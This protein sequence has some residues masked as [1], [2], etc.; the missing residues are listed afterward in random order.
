MAPL[1]SCLTLTDVHCRVIRHIVSI[2]SSQGLFDDLTSS[3]EEWALAQ[4]VEDEVK[5]PP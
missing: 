1:F 3:P 4:Q 2:R 5:P